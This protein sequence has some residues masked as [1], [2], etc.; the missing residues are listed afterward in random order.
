MDKWNILL[1]ILMIVMLHTSCQ[2]NTS[3]NT[4][5]EPKR[6]AIITASLPIDTSQVY[7]KILGALVGSAIGDAMGAPVE[8]WARDQINIQWGYIN[9]IVPVIREASPEGPWG[10][11]LP[12]GGTT[13][14]TRWKLLVSK[15]LESVPNQANLDADAFARWIIKAYEREQQALSEVESFDPQPIENASR[16][17]TWLQEWAKVAKPFAHNDLKG[18]NLALNRFYGGEMAC[19]GM[20]YGPFIGLIFPGEPIRAYENAYDLSFFD[21]GFARDI[22]G[23]TA[24][25]VSNAMSLNLPFEKINEVNY[26]VDP[27]HFFESRLIGRQ[28]YSIHRNAKNIAFQ[29]KQTKLDP[30]Q[31]Q[32]VLPKNYQRDSTFFIQL[33]AAYANLDNHLQTIPF[34][35]AEIFLIH[36]T[37]MEFSGGDFQV[38]MEFIT[39]Y[40]RDNDTVAAVT[41]AVMGAHLGYSNLPQ[42]LAQ[43]VL[44]IT[45]EIVQIDLEDMAKQLTIRQL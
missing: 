20:L 36:L 22:S 44:D 31:S 6:E 13:D 1:R 40:G 39:N 7:D 2:M 23:L 27:H 41:G 10:Y 25:A 45:K 15:Y 11:N 24:A 16:K 21:I 43:K 3:S 29:A 14:D 32:L 5:P 12:S 4:F 30:N 28:A 8:M 34:H 26:L 35:A 37:A 17:M 42:P 9:D 33:Q 38:A 18:Y 19:A